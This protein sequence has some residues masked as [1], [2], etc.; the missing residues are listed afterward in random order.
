MHL[1]WHSAWSGNL[2]ITSMLVDKSPLIL[3]GSSSRTKSLRESQLII[4]IEP[5]SIL[6]LCGIA[7]W[8]RIRAGRGSATHCLRVHRW[9][10]YLHWL[11]S[12]EWGVWVTHTH[13]LQILSSSIISL[14]NSIKFNTTDRSIYAPG[15]VLG[16]RH[17]TLTHGSSCCGDWRLWQFYYI[18]D[19]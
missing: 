4:N 11:S 15:L 3:G 5:A 10:T 16:T 8:T 2:F 18:Q 9:S 7:Q 13:P 12:A 14:N 1:I 6:R 19:N 17:R